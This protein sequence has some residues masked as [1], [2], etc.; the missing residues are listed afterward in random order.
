MHGGRDRKDGT[1]I[2]GTRIEIHNNTF[3]AP[4]TAVAIR[5]VPQE[6]CDIHHNWFAK[7]ARAEQAVRAGEKTWVKDNVY[8]EEPA[9][10]LGPDRDGARQPEKPEETSVPD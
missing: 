5:G 4:T 2:A 6:R 3:Q 9:R 8:G 10:W 1:T 7:H